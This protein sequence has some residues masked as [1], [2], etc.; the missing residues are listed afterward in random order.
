MG[1]EGLSL[2]TVR[3]QR[4]TTERSCVGTQNRLSRSEQAI[5]YSNQQEVESYSI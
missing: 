4:E 2:A 5:E 3:G 1:E